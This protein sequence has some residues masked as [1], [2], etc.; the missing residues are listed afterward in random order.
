MNR[1][2]GRPVL[3]RIDDFAEE[4][5]LLLRDGYLD[6]VDYGMRRCNAYA[7]WEWVLRL[8]YVATS[9]GALQDANPG[10]CPGQR[11]RH[12]RILVLIPGEVIHVL[13]T[14]SRPAGCHRGRAAGVA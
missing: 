9:A 1:L 8:R 7:E 6:R 2:Y 13:R 10:W 3:A 4:A 12:G 11:G 14:D 5:A